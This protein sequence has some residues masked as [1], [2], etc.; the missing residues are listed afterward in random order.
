LT[1]SKRVPWNPPDPA[2]VA[3]SELASPPPASA[4]PASID[5]VPDR[6]VAYRERQSPREGTELQVSR[7]QTR[8]FEPSRSRLARSLV[9]AAGAPTAAQFAYNRVRTQIV[10]RLRDSG[11][12]TI[13]VTSPV[14]GSGT[15]TTA[16]NLAISIARQFDCTALLVELNFR[17]PS[18]QRIMG[19]EQRYGIADH[20]LRGVPIP[21]I[22]LN[23]GIDRLNII[24][25]GSPV[26]NSS[27]LLAS[28]QMT[29]LVSELKHRYDD[30]I[31]LFD[32]PPVLAT[33]DAMAFSRLVD[34]ALF[35]VKE[36]ETRIAD[37]R[38]ALTYLRSTSLLGV[39]LNQSKYG[40]T[41][42]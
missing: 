11:W 20:L 34:C 2:A 26:V 12:N 39:V 40:E 3:K 30:R 41:S 38:Q 4:E 36:G 23:P 13:A 10:A 21:E 42:D 18:F 31:V 28:P 22:M 15:T 33:D 17:N 16:I 35:V 27:E 32:L 19:F 29:R 25:A 6:T 7:R 24:P 5:N 9:I 37:V 14:R 8:Q 1:R